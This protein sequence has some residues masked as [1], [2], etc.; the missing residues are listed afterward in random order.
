MDPDKNVGWQWVDLD[1]L[2]EPDLYDMV[3]PTVQK[4]KEGK[5]Y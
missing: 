2:S 4:F 3:L 5:F 1:Q